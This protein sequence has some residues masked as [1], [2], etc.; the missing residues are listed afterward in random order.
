MT[1]QLEW[2]MLTDINHKEEI[3]EVI[4]EFPTSSGGNSKT[5]IERYR[6]RLTHN[7]GE[8]CH[9]PIS[10]ESWFWEYSEFTSLHVLPLI[11]CTKIKPNL[12]LTFKFVLFCVFFITFLFQPKSITRSVLIVDWL[13]RVKLIKYVVR[14]GAMFLFLWFVFIIFWAWSTAFTV[15]FLLPQNLFE[16]PNSTL[17]AF[18][19]NSWFLWSW[20]VPLMRSLYF[21]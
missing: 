6:Y 3:N 9:V 16:F 8:A 12:I 11:V 21:I 2:V 7:E 17:F 15:W 18:D 13:A 19:V 10:L 20:F 5:Q 14:Y 1:I 4:K